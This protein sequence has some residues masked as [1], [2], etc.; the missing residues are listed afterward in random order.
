MVP[1]ETKGPKGLDRFLEI[2]G[3]PPEIVGRRI[4]VLATNVVGEPPGPFSGDLVRLMLI[5][6]PSS[7]PSHA[8]RV[9]IVPEE[10]FTLGDSITII[11]KDG[12]SHTF[13]LNGTDYRPSA[14]DDGISELT[15][16][17]LIEAIIGGCVT[18]VTKG[19]PK[20]DSPPVAKAIVLHDALP[21]WAPD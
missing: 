11:D 6:S 13:T 1:R 17:E 4:A 15:G 2:V 12:E 20:A 19:D 8:H 10:G 14:E 7:P 3:D 5:P 21:D 16:E 9:G 18:V